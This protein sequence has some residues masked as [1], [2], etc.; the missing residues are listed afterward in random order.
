LVTPLH[1][2]VIVSGVP[3]LS[4]SGVVKVI[5]EP[6][7]RACDRAPEEIGDHLGEG[8]ATREE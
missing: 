7:R 6:P 5:D 2:Y 4:R 8:Q 3:S 1:A